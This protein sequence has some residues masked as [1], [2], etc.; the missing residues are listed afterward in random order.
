[1]L[2]RVGEGQSVESLP[3]DQYPKPRITGIALA[4]FDA[5]IPGSGK[6]TIGGLTVDT[7]DWVGFSPVTI[8]SRVE[9]LSMP[10]DA[11]EDPMLRERVK[12]L[13]LDILTVNSAIDLGWKEADDT[14]SFGP[15]SV[16]ID[17]IGKSTLSGALGGVP[18]DIFQ[19]P[20]MADQAIA[21]LDFR[22]ASLAMQDGGSFAK[23]LDMLAKEQGMSRD[24]LAQLASQQVQGGMIMMLGME[25][26][27]K[28]VGTALRDFIAN[29]KSLR[30][31]IGTTEP[32]PAIAFTKISE[33]D[34]TALSLI[35]K[36]VTIDAVANQ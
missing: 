3:L 23:L 31:D 36:S 25:D 5:S 9:G 2:D 1:M 18:K 19:N 17:G 22:G 34:E 33:G 16:D 24:D 4:D 21:T 10:A 20:A 11:I 26:A 28:K 12:A 6:F 13:G 7:P 29:P 35:K 30:V 15:V 8:K 32:I 14:L 27:A